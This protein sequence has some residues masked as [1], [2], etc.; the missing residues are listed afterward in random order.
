M[1]IYAS[2][3]SLVVFALLAMA[4]LTGCGSLR[5]YSEVRDQQGAA[6]QKAWTDVDLTGLVATERENLKKLLDAE[7]DTQG[8]LA[9]GIRDHELRAMVEASSLKEGLVDRVNKRLADV[10]GDGNLVAASRSKLAAFRKRTIQLDAV[11]EE[12]KAKNLALP[13]CASVANGATPAAI[14]Q[15]RKTAPLRD[16]AEVDGALNEMRKVCDKPENDIVKAVYTGLGGEVDR[17]LKEYVEDELALKKSEERALKLRTEYQ[18]ALAAYEKA[19]A[20]NEIKA[21][22]TDRVRTALGKLNEAVAA[23]DAAQDALSIQFLSKERL[24]ALDTFVH[25]VTEAKGD[26]TVPE[27][28]SKATVAFVLLP[29]LVDDARASLAE[30]RK[31]L[32]LPLLMRRNHE[33]LKVEAANREI[34]ARRARIRLSKEIVEANYE[35]AVQLW[36]ASRDLNSAGVKA[37]HG[38]RFSEAFT[39]A[40]PNEK[41]MLYMSAARYLDAIN[42]LSARRYKLEYMR[43]ATSHELALAYAEVDMKQWQSLIGATVDQVAAFGA[44]GIKA[45]QVSALLNTI[46]IFWIGHG[47]N[48]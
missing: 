41:E 24:A 27:G 32:A 25:S 26:G 22:A 38:R 6:A 36:L 47:V 21:D 20:E 18:V 23:L 46:G 39:V 34:E 7:L 14:E 28:A 1:P 9:T 44:G 33:Q 8:R 19:V 13:T 31:P 29:G 30:A 45:E 43:I 48:K 16:L 5:L 4:S 10:A 15:W 37:L 35:Q 3:C 42:R 2:R 17:S 12:L 11:A 40:G